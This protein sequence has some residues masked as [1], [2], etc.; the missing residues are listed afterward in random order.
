MANII[1]TTSIDIEK[2]LENLNLFKYHPNGIVNI[3]VNRLK[4]ML[5]GKVELVDPSNPFVYL[6]ETSSLNT[7]FAVQEY[8]LQT[9][10]LYPRLANKDED[11]YLHMSDY[12]FLGRFSEPSYADIQFNVLF[13]DFKT[14]AY[15]D[16]IQKEY[17]LKLPRHLKVLVNKYV[18]L[19]PSAIVI[20][21]T[22]N[23]I[24]DVKFENQ[25]FNNIFDIGTKY[26]NFNL[27]TYRQN[28][29]YLNFNLKLPEIDIETFDIPIDTSSVFNDYIEYNKNRKFYFFRAFYY[30]NN[31][32]REMLVTHTN[33]VYDLNTP[34]CIIK[35]L[36]TTNRV[37]YNIPSV[38]TVTG[39]IGTKV[40]FLVY[41]TL[42]RI[43]V[44]FNDY[45]ISDFT[46][47]YGNVFPSEELDNYTRPI[48]QITKIIYTKDIIDSGKD[49]LTF[50][51]LKD[52]VIE[53]SIGDRK[54]PITEKQLSF[55]S[56]QYNFNIIKSVDIVS[57]RLYKLETEIPS[58]LT[59]YPIT[60]YNLDI[61]EY[62]TTIAKLRQGN[63]VISYNSDIT[64]IPEGTLFKLDD[65]VLIHLSIQEYNQIK[66][67]TDI[68]LVNAVNNLNYL[69]TYYHYILDTSG[70]RT[71]LRA[72]DLTYPTVEHISFKEFNSTARVGLNTINGNMFKNS[73]GY[74]LDILSSLKKYTDTIDISNIN[75]YLIYE[76]VAGSVYYLQGSHLT[77]IN[78]NPVFRF[79]L[80]TDYYIDKNNNIHVTNFK[81]SNGTTTTVS[82]NI[83]SKL[84]ILYTSNIIPVNFVSSNIDIYIN[85]SYISGSA[86]GV[87]IEEID[88]VF[89]YYLER[90]YTAVHSSTG[91]Y[92]YETYLDDVP[93]RYTTNVYDSSN[94]IIHYVNDI[95]IDP[96]TS[97]PIIKF[98]KGSVKLD[99][100]NTPIPINTLDM[101][102]YINL[103]FIDY[104]V[105]LVTVQNSIEYDKQIKQ[106]I[107]EV[108]V[109]NANVIQNDLLDNSE[110][111]V[112][113]P[114]TI[115]KVKVKTDLVE[116]VI[117][118]MQ[119]YSVDVYVS[120]SVF[121]NNDIRDNISYTIIKTIDDY[122]YDNTILKKT[123][124]LNILYTKLS[125]F[126]V[127]I[128]LEQTLDINTEYIEL[129]DRNSRLSL[130]KILTTEIDGYKLKE[131]ISVNF[132]PIN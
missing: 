116:K 124:L 93:L 103:L 129:V 22:E 76:D 15:Y 62:Q 51:E 14:K 99:E 44:N 126:I 125:E 128:S 32:W 19:L 1:P 13:S 77:D 46:T 68:E 115:D 50:E 75:T 28:E 121:N 69:S 78:N 10:K 109:E 105:K 89:G 122:L 3:S 106:H 95:V 45:Q 96:D 25:D 85:N 117:D 72:Y 80:D 83:N 114:K 119:S 65:G 88:L 36:P 38:Y 59:R 30:L 92:E 39:M 54:L 131:D 55:K 87:T 79:L 58:P 41:T 57:N 2:E 7:A 16:P 9:R 40:K 74:T 108:T 24:I 70:D 63:N 123:E 47:E 21:L 67:L 82:F 90:L 60:K 27:L 132:K 97:E 52:A 112:V 130:N 61:L 100:F 42:G 33:E 20:R 71:T 37:Q 86:C 35:V 12:D 120:Y 26:I 49:G 18:F 66:S 81:D 111:Y 48:Q 73:N 104:R 23:D 107:T 84:K 43:S 98:P 91:T 64:V 8:A 4:D 101:E 127:S 17:V 53:N 110:A 118:S 56:N 102:R 6:L 34:T 31:E 94:N 29:T 5:D 113:I 11:L